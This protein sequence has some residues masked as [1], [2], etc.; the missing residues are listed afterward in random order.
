[1][2]EE[3]I[4]KSAFMTYMGHYEFPVMPFR[5]T[6]ALAT[7]QAL[8]N[9]IFAPFLRKFVLVFFDDI[10]IYS[11]SLDDHAL[12]LTEVLSTLRAN[13]L[14]A[15]WSKCVFPSPQVEYLSHIIYAMGVA[16]DPA[17]IS[18]IRNWPQPKSIS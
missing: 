16:T 6:N 8:M 12:H 18:T 10:L 3:D 17:K 15:K 2:K 5:L 11:K 9:A 13:S 1:M 7:F 14:T 4:H